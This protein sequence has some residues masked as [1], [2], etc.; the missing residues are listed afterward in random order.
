MRFL[1]IGVGVWKRK[2]EGITGCI[3]ENQPGVVG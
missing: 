3:V 2:F 1:G